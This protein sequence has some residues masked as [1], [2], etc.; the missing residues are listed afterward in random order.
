MRKKWWWKHIYCW[1]EIFMWAQ[2]L[3]AENAFAV[4]YKRKE[5]QKI[6]ELK[7]NIK[8]SRQNA[9]A[10]MWKVNSEYLIS[11]SMKN[12]MKMFSCY[13]NTHLYDFVSVD[14]TL[15]VFVFNIQLFYLYA[16][17]ATRIRRTRCNGSGSDHHTLMRKTFLK[18]ATGTLYSFRSV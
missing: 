9:R 17:I 1:K 3:R 10:Y 18:L 14:V 15:A 11:K 5:E 2:Q 7:R 12:L 16:C 13:F 4:D 8:S 6:C